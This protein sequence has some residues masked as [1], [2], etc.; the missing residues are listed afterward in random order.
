M[1]YHVLSWGIL[2]KGV[3]EKIRVFALWSGKVVKEV[4]ICSGMDAMRRKES[5][6]GG[7]LNNTFLEGRKN[8]V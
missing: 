4:E 6:Y 1:V 7:Y 3:L 2:V 5:F 8:R